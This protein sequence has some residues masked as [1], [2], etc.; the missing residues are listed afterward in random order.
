MKNTILVVC[1]IIITFNLT[2]FAYANWSTSKTNETMCCKTV[3]SNEINIPPNFVFDVDSRFIA[4]ITKQDL[5]NAKTI[6]DI[7]PKDAGWDKMTFWN[8]KVNILNLKGANKYEMGKDETLTPAQIALLKTADYS[9]NFNIEAY[10]K[11]D[12]SSVYPYY[13]TII[14]ETEASY[15]GG[16][17]AIINYL[18][19]NSEA[20]IAKTEKGNLKSGKAR[21]TISKEGMIKN[22]NLE[23][24]SGYPTVDKK[25]IQLIPTIP[26]IWI[27]AKNEKGETVEQEL[28]F[29]FGA[30][31]C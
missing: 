4:N 30:I 29:S 27:P 9:T 22:V 19:K 6:L 26:G 8:V 18:K 3:A 17:D 7:V 20:T 14:P 13:F 31:G 2:A 23:L 15:L 25:M 24:S 11:K 1:T 21:F 5:R 12:P 10:N 28:V 16:K